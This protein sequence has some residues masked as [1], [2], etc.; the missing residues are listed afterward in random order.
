MNHAKYERALAAISSAAVVLYDFNQ[1]YT[2]NELEDYLQSIAD[3]LRSQYE[4]ELTKIL[5]KHNV[6]L[7]YDGFGLDH[8]GLAINYLHG[9]NNSGYKIVYAVDEHARDHQPSI[10]NK[11][12]GADIVF[13]YISTEDSYL[14]WV[15]QLI[16][17]FIRYEP[18]A[19]MFYTTP[20][21]VAAH[22]AF[23]LY[24]DI[25][26]RFLIDLTDHAFWLGTSCNDFFIGSREMSASNELYK[27][28]LSKN[29]LIKLDFDLIV[30]EEWSG[31]EL[32]FDIEHDRYIFSGGAIYKTLGDKNSTYYKIID[33]IL[34]NHK[35]VKFLYAGEGDR[36][37]LIALQKA[38]PGRVFL[39]HERKD[40]YY[41]IK[42]CV[43][44][45]NTYP[46]FGGMMMR[47]SALAGKLPITLKHNSDSDG[48]LINQREAKID[49][50]TFNDLT[51][52]VDRL[53][54]DEDY[55][56][57][58]EKLLVGKILTEELFAK[59]LHSAIENHVT[60]YCHEFIELDTSDFQSEFYNRFNLTKSKRKLI[61]HINRSLF[62][63]LPWILLY[64]PSKL[65]AKLLNQMKSGGV[66]Q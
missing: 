26:S 58:R 47:F 57:Q 28:Y 25:G 61:S 65:V 30:D 32:P 18:K 64:A 21:D 22:V 3:K 10:K 41:L 50:D 45:L 16:N 40:F 54:T 13:E 46:M 56:R 35:D 20:W 23:T 51:S 53:L 27:R 1:T 43:L 4:P 42:H 8:R 9:L 33:Y 55:L 48:L 34:N 29:K 44:Y 31:E 63:S 36:T 49:Y 5:P 37:Q 2:D 6:V 19:L 39:I 38:H 7:F 14:Q 12:I 59:N 66:S 15:N 52:D 60:D 62:L 11:M 24:G 17:A